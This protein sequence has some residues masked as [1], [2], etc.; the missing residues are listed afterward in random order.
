MSCTTYNFDNNKKPGRRQV[1]HVDHVVR[2]HVDPFDDAQ[3]DLLGAG[4]SSL[5]NLSNTSKE[6]I[7]M[8]LHA[9]ETL[10]CVSEQPFAGGSL[11]VP[12]RPSIAQAHGPF[13]WVRW[14]RGPLSTVRRHSWIYGARK[15]KASLTAKFACVNTFVHNHAQEQGWERRRLSPPWPESLKDTKLSLISMHLGRV[16]NVKMLINV[17]QHEER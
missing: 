12:D 1:H 3:Q 13:R 14:S 4:C 11:A 10:D 2:S 15:R 6:H 17:R 7:A 16:G 8:N 5:L 9:G